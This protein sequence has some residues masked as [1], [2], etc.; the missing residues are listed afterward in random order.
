MLK[1]WICV[2]SIFL[3]YV[4]SYS[5]GVGEMEDDGGKH[6]STSPAKKEDIEPGTY[7]RT[8][9]HGGLTR[10]YRMHIPLTYTSAKQHALVLA[11]H[12]GRGTGKGTEMLTGLTPLSD[13]EGFIVVYPDGIGR[14]WNDGRDLSRFQAM[15]DQVDD[16]GF[17]ATLIDT[18]VKRLSIDPNR[19]FATGISNGGH[20]VNRLGIELSEKLA[21]IAPVAGTVAKRIAKDRHPTH[22]VAVIYFHGTQDRFNFW[23]G[24]GRAGGD[25]LSVP[26]LIRWWVQHNGCPVTPKKEGLA[27]KIDDG[28]TVEREIF[29]PGKNGIEVV[30]YIIEAGGHTW[31]GGYQYL[32]ESVIGKTTGNLD[33]SAV[34]WEFFSR[35]PRKTELKGQTTDDR[36]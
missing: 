18:L 14:T 31:P 32:P 25:T 30:L 17:T 26:D 16:V 21:A 36:R 15:K 6:D 8:L 23:D 11:F 35:H 7:N 9:D 24:G 4:S 10:S 33:A 2:L 3:F 1:R 27:V 22:P 28:T 19:V 12:G 29:G 5:I 13:R 34:M 20:M